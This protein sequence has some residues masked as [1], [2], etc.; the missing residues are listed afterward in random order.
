MTKYQQKMKKLFD[1]HFKNIPTLKERRNMLKSYKVVINK[2]EVAVEDTALNNAKLVQNT[3]KISKN[4]YTTYLVAKDV[5]DCL[6]IA[7]QVHFDR[8]KTAAKSIEIEKISK[9]INFDSPETIS[10]AIK[11][12]VKEVMS[13]EREVA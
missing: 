1:D 12:L 8:F 4:Q 13:D 11:N 9:K 5:Y 2:N 7:K 10:S 6:S 3:K